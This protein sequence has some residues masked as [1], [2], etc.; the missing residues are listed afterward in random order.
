M[1]IKLQTK[2][3]DQNRQAFLNHV[4]PHLTKTKEGL[5]QLNE[6][7][8]SSFVL[9]DCCGW[10]YRALWPDL[11]IIGL[12]T[13]YGIKEY[14]L[15]RSKF[16][17]IIDNRDYYNII[18]PSLS[19]AGH[20]LVFDHSSILKYRTIDGII[21]VISSAVEKYQPTIIVFRALTLF[22]DDPRLGDRLVSLSSLLIPGYIVT[23]F[24]YDTK[25]VSITYKRKVDV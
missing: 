21:D 22:I 23:K 19:V 3:T 15:E 14:N 13:L 2:V 12:E 11:N 16:Q 8:V 9:A 10:H 5:V 20:A 17:G 24:M 18:W 1:E 7:D 6:Y 25:N 4:Y